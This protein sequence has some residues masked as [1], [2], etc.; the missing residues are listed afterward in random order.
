LKTSSSVTI[1]ITHLPS[2]PFLSPY[3]SYSQRI[4]LEILRVLFQH[5]YLA[6][7]EGEKSSL[8]KEKGK[9]KKK[10]KERRRKDIKLMRFSYPKY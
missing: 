9:D 7:N 1:T 5:L 4:F 3:L 6:R 8:E 2:L 10:Y